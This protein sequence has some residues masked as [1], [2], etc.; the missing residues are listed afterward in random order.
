MIQEEKPLK[1]GKKLLALLV[2][3]CMLLCMLPTVAFASGSDYLKI[4]MLDS[5]RKYFSADWV[6]AFLYEAKADGY[7]HVMLAVGNDGMRFLLDDMSLTVGGKTYSSNAVASAI[8]AGN[9]AYT[10]ASSGEWTES[11]MDEFFATAKKAGIEIIPL[12]NS[13]G[14]MD[15]VLYAASS[16]TGTNCSYNGSG[17]TIDVTNDTAVRFSQAFLQKYVDYFAGKGCRYFNF[18]A[19]EYANDRYTSGSMGFGSL[20]NSGKY[21]YFIKYVNELAAMVKQAGMTPIAFNDGIEFANKMSAS[22]GST[23]YTF[24]R[25]IVVCYWS[26]GWSGYTPRTA[27]NLASDG[28]RIINTTGDFYYV[29]GKNDSFDNG[30]TYA[31]NWSNY[32]VCG[33]SL[34]ASSV[35]GGMFRM[36]SDYPGAETQTQ[37]AKKIRLP[38]RAMGLAMDGAYTSGMDTSVVP[39]ASTPTAPSTPILP[40]R[41]T[42]TVRLPRRLRPARR[43]AA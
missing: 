31:A 34:S 15:A 10:T 36:W 18:G 11:E 25:D 12:L 2:T 24:D 20:Q 38:L 19:D 35:I 7:T 43:R 40:R 29:L 33:T 14:H 8:R 1:A 37:E 27:A 3:V 9:N 26:G 4:A 22:V 42:T 16:L 21:G 28:F 39:A 17:R 41:A 13:P 6:K 32:K 30:Y 5:G 23:T